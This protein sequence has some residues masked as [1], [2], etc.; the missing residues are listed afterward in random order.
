MSVTELKKALKGEVIFGTNIVIKKLKLGKLKKVFLAKN[1]KEDIREDILY[2]AR[3]AKV[4]VI[5]LKIP[6][7]EVGLICRKPFS[8]SVI[9]Y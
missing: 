2:Y 8:I 3:L 7:D 5:Q 6:N 1:C 9:G 4:E